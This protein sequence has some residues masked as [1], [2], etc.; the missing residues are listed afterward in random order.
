MAEAKAAQAAG[1]LGLAYAKFKAVAAVPG[2]QDVR[3][4]AA[5]GRRRD[6]ARRPRR[7]SRPPT[8]P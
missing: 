4:E 1:K 7:N 8:P 5:P 2:G 6:R 3:Q